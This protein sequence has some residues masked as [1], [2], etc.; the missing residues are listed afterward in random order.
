MWKEYSQMRYYWDNRSARIRERK[1]KNANAITKHH[2]FVYF[3]VF[4]YILFIRI[5]IVHII[6]HNFMFSISITTAAAAT[7]EEKNRWQKKSQ[8]KCMKIPSKCVP[9]IQGTR[10]HMKIKHHVTRHPEERDRERARE[11]FKFNRF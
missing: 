10:T 11:K 7:A 5:Y 9:Y 1:F 4:A 3:G 6:I 2:S 8:H